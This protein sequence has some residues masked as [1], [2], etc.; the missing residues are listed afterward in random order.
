[1]PL[2]QGSSQATIS[3]NIREL[4]TGATYAR[5]RRKKGKSAA[6][7]QAV[8]IALAIAARSKRHKRTTIVGK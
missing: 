5:E 8:A 6:D 3:G 4:H 7:K 2:K 1:M